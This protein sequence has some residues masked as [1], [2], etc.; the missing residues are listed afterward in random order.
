MIGQDG[1]H[2]L[3]ALTH[4]DAPAQL[5]ALGSWAGAAGLRSLRRQGATFG[6]APG[7]PMPKRAIRP[8]I[9]RR[10]VPRNARAR[11]W[12]SKGISPKPASHVPRMAHVMVHVETTPATPTDVERTEPLHTGLAKP[13]LVPAE[14]ALD[15]GYIDAQ[16]RVQSPRAVGH[17][18]ASVLCCPTAEGLRGQAKASMWLISSW[19]GKPAPVTCPPWQKSRKWREGG[20]KDERIQVECAKSSCAA[21]PVRADCTR[22]TPAGRESNWRPQALYEAR[23]RSTTEADDPRVPTAVCHSCGGASHPRARGAYDGVATCT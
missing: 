9:P 20:E 2:L 22:Q 3:A 14:Q 12:A 8:L 5:S 1:Q 21:C 18:Q 13:Q 6:Q 19:T 4:C 23:P 16:W 11:G 15:T 10:A 17:A 7:C